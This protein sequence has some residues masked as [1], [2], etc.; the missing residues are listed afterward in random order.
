V[1]ATAEKEGRLFGAIQ[2][3]NSPNQ[4]FSGAEMEVLRYIGLCGAD[5]LDRV[6][7]LHT[8]IGL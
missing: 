3:I 4:G 6:S 5:I 8:V 2:L 7:D 1:C